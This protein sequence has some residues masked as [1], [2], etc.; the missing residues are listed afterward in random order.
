MTTTPARVRR[1]RIVRR[2]I[3]LSE[4]FDA[5]S[6]AL[7]EKWGRRLVRVFELDSLLEKAGINQH[8]VIFASRVLL[9]TTV[10]ILT[11]TA[12]LAVATAF[13]EMPMGLRLICIVFAVLAPII[14][15]TLGLM[16]PN[17]TA[18]TRRMMVDNEL[19]FFMAYVST[20][21][22]GGVSV[23]RVIER[24]ANLKIFKYLR[25][26][27]QR[28]MLHI[29]FFGEDPLSAIEKVTR[30][31]PSS[32]FRDLMLGYTTTLRTGGDVLHYLEIRTQEL[33]AART[34]EIK[35]LTEKMGSFLEIYIV[36]GVI[37][38][39]T[40]F[41][42]FA[43]SGAL[44]MAGSRAGGTAMFHFAGLTGTQN[45]ATPALYNFLV[46]PMLGVMVL[47]MAHS[48]QPKNPV[49][50]LEPYITLV[51][52]VPFA[53]V[54]FFV[55]L[56]VT[57]GMGLFTGRFGMAEVKSVIMSLAVALLMLS[58]PPWIT[59]EKQLR[60]MRG[61][62][63]STAD[64]LRDLSEVRKTG[65]SPEKCIITLA[66]RDYRNLTPVVKRAGA[67]LA[68]GIDL[69]R[70]LRN[71]L[72]GVKEWF[73]ITIFRFLTDS[74]TV[75]GGSPEII[76]ALARF[77][78]NLAESE[79]EMRRKLKAYVAL[80][81]FGAIM[82]AAAPLVILWLLVASAKGVTPSSMAPLVF[83]LSGGALINNFV[84]GIVAGKVSDMSVAAGFKHATF[85]ILITAVTSLLTMKLLGL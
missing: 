54:A 11:I 41:V 50:K 22:R 4:V 13:V 23:D 8:P 47:A 80:P 38:S 5:L 27:A 71:A 51:V 14:T 46:L 26:E 69:E 34:A 83:I 66:E 77:T 1:K 36:L 18:S 12:P 70:A 79:E 82:L 31:H 68:T 62:I 6:L 57:G 78:Q 16:Y 56:S 29:K 39:I 30:N 42:F 60:G 84:M 40:L 44:S 72:R 76:D 43:V 33:F 2:R 81:Y 74:I 67:A 59:Y 45:L 3:T 10:I 15:F 53:F 21:V 32:K 37:T 7:F 73:V 58:I 24:V 19:P 55:T 75:G 28:I 25:E 35:S 64:F 65:L 49:S 63:K 85:M 48:S 20:M 61:I 9:M 52:V 17:M